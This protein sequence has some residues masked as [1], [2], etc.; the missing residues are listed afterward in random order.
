M[1]DV[2]HETVF[3]SGHVQGV[4]FRYAVLQTAKEFEVAGFV[5]NLADGRVQLEAEGASDE[6]AAFVSAVEEKMHGFIRKVERA[7]A[8]RAP[9]FRG[10]AIR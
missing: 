9:E 8:T 2:H 5:R 4:G 3:F 7:S 10:F 6:I 1:P